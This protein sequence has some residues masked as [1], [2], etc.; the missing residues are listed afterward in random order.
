[1]PCSFA[2]HLNKE[3]DLHQRRERLFYEHLGNLPVLEHYPTLFI[4]YYPDNELHKQRVLDLANQ[5]TVAKIPQQNIYID[6]W[7]NRP[8][9]EYTTPQH[10]DLIFKSD[11]VLVIGSLGLKENYEKGKGVITQEIENLRSRSAFQGPRGLIP[12]FFDGE[13]REVFPQG[14]VNLSSRSLAGNYYLRFFDLLID[15]YGL[16]P[17]D[18]PIKLI[19]EEFKRRLNNLPQETLLPYK[20]R[21]QQEHQ[22]RI[23]KEK[24]V[25]DKT[26]LSPNQITQ[27]LEYTQSKNTKLEKKKMNKDSVKKIKSELI[28]PIE[29]I[30]LERSKIIKKMRKF[31]KEKLDITTIALT[32]VGGSGKTTIARYYAQYQEAPVNWEINAETEETLLQSFETLGYALPKTKREQNLL[33]ELGKLE[34]NKQKREKLILFVREKLK[35]YSGWLLVYDNVDKFMDIAEYFPRNHE[36]WGRGQV[37]ITTRNSHIISNNY[38]NHVVQVN[39]LSSSEKLDLFLKIRKR[40]QSK[41]LTKF[42]KD[43]AGNFLNHIPSFPLDVSIAA[44]YFNANEISYEEYLKYLKEYSKNFEMLQQN[45]LREVSEYNKTRYSIISLSMKQMIDTDKNFLS[46]LILISLLDSQNIPRSLLNIYKDNTIVDSFVFDLKKYSLIT[47]ETLPHSSLLPAISLHRSTQEISLAYLLNILNSKEYNQLFMLAVLNLEDYIYDALEKE[48][49][50]KMKLLVSHCESFLNHK[51]LVSEGVEGLISGALGCIYYYQCNYE[52]A[53]NLLKQGLKN[54]DKYDNKNY[55]KIAQ[56]SLYLGNVYRSL[57]NYRKSI[58]LLKISLKTYKK[59]PENH[60]GIARSLG[61]L[62]YAFREVGNYEKSKKLLEKGFSIYRAHV[63]EDSI[64]VAWISAHLGMTCRELG[65]YEESKRL[66]E[67]S[68]ETYEKYPGNHVGVAW[69]LGHLGIVHLKEEKY[70]E[71][72]DLFERAS[73]IY[74]K[75]FSNNHPYVNWTTSYLGVIHTKLGNH[76]KS[77]NFLEN[78]L[79]IYQENEVTNYFEIARVLRSLGQLF[80]EQ[81]MLD[82]AEK[83]ITESIV[84]YQQRQHPESYASL[85]ALAGIYQRRSLYAL[86]NK[87]LEKFHYFKKKAIDHL[88]L[89]LNIMKKYFPAEFPLKS[90]IH[91]KIYEVSTYKIDELLNNLST[92]NRQDELV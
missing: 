37:I 84:M 62:G 72:K 25:W 26:L 16:N 29:P 81:D 7:T 85:E 76:Q 31:F 12:T 70:E 86:S 75:Y 54:L 67:K 40:K 4:T 78:S 91:K 21:L 46:L 56:F 90:K 45:I 42:Q 82:M 15:I 3:E 30:L 5:L 38:V 34:N 64:P 71:A 74:R 63:P 51:S 47:G 13:A 36:S 89:S 77:K 23:Q 28:M 65:N 39:E 27:C 61:Y 6:E 9:S 68:L 88:K 14:L 43:E 17:R 66:L 53:E 22:E 10:S 60:A 11:K 83:F 79:K 2:S 52:K 59:Q 48:D 58:D 20:G 73:R 35:T 87:D 57:G 18:N 1:M 49:F 33:K 44:H 41:E 80:T 19:F 8:G 92:I 50:V 24:E 32:G 69:I 55:P